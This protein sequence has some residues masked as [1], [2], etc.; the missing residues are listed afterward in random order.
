MNEFSMNF[1]VILEYIYTLFITYLCSHVKARAIASAFLAM[2]LHFTLC[3]II[4][5]CMYIYTLY[6]QLKHMFSETTL[7]FTMCDTL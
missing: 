7:I 4:H 1:E 5:I 3:L 2:T 6:I